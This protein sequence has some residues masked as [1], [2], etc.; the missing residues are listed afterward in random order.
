VVVR[1]VTGSL[2][3]TAWLPRLEERVGAS[4]IL[5][6]ADARTRPQRTH[7][8]ATLVALLRALPG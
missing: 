3:P 4:R 6:V 1:A 7:L 2:T 5:T 8:E